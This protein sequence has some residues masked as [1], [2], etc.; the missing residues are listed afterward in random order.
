MKSKICLLLLCVFNSCYSQNDTFIDN[1]KVINN[2]GFSMYKWIF[3]KSDLDLPIDSAYFINKNFWNYEFNIHFT[4]LIKKT[5]TIYCK[6]L[7]NSNNK[8]TLILDKQNKNIINVQITNDSSV[9]EK[10]QFLIVGP[11]EFTTIISSD[12]MMK[13]NFEYSISY[14]LCKIGEWSSVNI[15]K[16]KVK[17]RFYKFK[18][19]INVLSIM[20]NDLKQNKKRSKV[21]NDLTGEL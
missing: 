16:P 11:F 21:Y 6:K 13:N 10:G 8:I 12:I 3:N 15:T 9:I 20:K 5:D 1:T 19:K 7:S 17:L 4:R 14:Y 18:N 2:S